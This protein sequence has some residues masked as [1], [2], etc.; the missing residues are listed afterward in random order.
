MLGQWYWPCARTHNRITK[1]IQ[2]IKQKYPH[3]VAGDHPLVSVELVRVAASLGHR[4]T[5][6]ATVASA[7]LDVSIAAKTPS[8]PPDTSAAHAYRRSGIAARDFARRRRVASTPRDVDAAL[9]APHTSTPAS[10]AHDLA[11]RARPND[12]RRR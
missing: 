4:L 2:G 7:R 10:D 1:H 9:S 8:L 12:V 5:R 11:R 6:H 3:D